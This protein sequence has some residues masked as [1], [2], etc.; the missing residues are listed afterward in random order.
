MKDETAA[1][2]AESRHEA[3]AG[4]CA[5][6]ASV[7]QLPPDEICILRVQ[8]V[9]VIEQACPGAGVALSMQS[10]GMRSKNGRQRPF[11]FQV[12]SIGQ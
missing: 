4:V 6:D 7:V 3:R 12:T 10:T 5:S 1:C 9:K 8:L 2:G 11:F